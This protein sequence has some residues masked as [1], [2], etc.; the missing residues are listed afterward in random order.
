MIRWHVS[1]A[2]GFTTPVFHYEIP[3]EVNDLDFLR[4]FLF[5]KGQFKNL[6]RMEYKDD[7]TFRWEFDD[8]LLYMDE[9]GYV[10]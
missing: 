7:N 8:A 1:L 4:N 3:L 9:H 5:F 6:I 2:C 10:I